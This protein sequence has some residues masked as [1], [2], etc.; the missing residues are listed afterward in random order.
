MAELNTT[1]D[2]LLGQLIQRLDNLT[3]EISALVKADHTQELSTQKL[4]LQLLHIQEGNAVKEAAIAKAHSRL[5]EL[6]EAQADSNKK[7]IVWL[8][9]A[10]GS[11]ILGIVINATGWL[12]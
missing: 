7:L 3:V 1:T 5:D 11:A 8:A 10:I 2:A 9:T 4:Q 6:L 12:K